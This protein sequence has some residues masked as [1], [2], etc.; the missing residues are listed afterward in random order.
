VLRIP[1]KHWVRNSC[2]ILCHVL[3][4]LTAFLPRT[5]RNMPTW[6]QGIPN[7]CGK[8][9]SLPTFRHTAD[10]SAVFQASNC[11]QAIAVE[12]IEA[13]PCICGVRKCERVPSDEAIGDVEKLV[14]ELR[15]IHYRDH[16]PKPLA[17]PPPRVVRKTCLLNSAKTTERDHSSAR[18]V[19][20]NR[21]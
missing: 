6:V 17:M 10:A 2:F 8:G 4:P 3:L 12:G 18:V 16:H 7:C 15:A 11:F 20:E 13:R 14:S 1:N 19:H 5:Q 21:K 9:S